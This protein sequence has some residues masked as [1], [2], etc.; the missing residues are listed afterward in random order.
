MRV[1]TDHWFDTLLAA[2]QA[3]LDKLQQ[4]VDA[5]SLRSLP[6]LKLF[7]I[8]TK[9]QEQAVVVHVAYAHTI[10]KAA[11]KQQVDAATYDTA[12]GATE[13]T[14]AQWPAHEAELFAGLIS[15]IYMGGLL[16]PKSDNILWQTNQ[17][18]VAHPDIAQRFIDALRQ[19][20]ILSIPLWS[21][22]GAKLM[23]VRVSA[24]QNA[25][26]LSLS[27]TWFNLLRVQQPQLQQMGD[28]SKRESIAA[29]RRLMQIAPKFVD[30]V[31]SLEMRDKRLVART[32]RG[33]L[34][35]YVKK[36]QERFVSSAKTLQFTHIR[37]TKDG[38]INAVVVP[39]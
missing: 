24:E 14:L 10:G 2:G 22:E 25:V 35:G 11:S 1:A 34:F 18:D 16:T 12:Y 20:G 13:Q 28:V 9:W 39:Q 21:D 33:N 31:L 7:D 6:P 32:A 3:H 8:G 38:N 36:G 27:G 4:Q 5:L 19:L 23:C 26:P 15:L 30:Q 29:K 37:A 17:R